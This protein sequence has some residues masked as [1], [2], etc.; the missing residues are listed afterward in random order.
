MNAIT[1]IQ[2]A[3]VLT[4]PLNIRRGAFGQITDGVP[5]SISALV[6]KVLTEIKF[7]EGVVSR[8][9]RGGFDAFNAD[10][11]GFD[12]E[13]NLVAIQLRHS[14]KRRESD[15]LN[16]HKWYALA[17]ID[18]GQLFSH[19]IPTSFRRNPDIMRASAESVVRWAESKIFGVPL[20]R[21]GTIIR[22][23]DVALVPVRS[24]PRSA[25][26]IDGK[27]YKYVFC[28]SH[29][30]TIDGTAYIDNS[31]ARHWADG[32]VQIDHLPGQHRS[33][34]GQGRFEIVVGE[35]LDVDFS[36]ID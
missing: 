34:D 27:D 18:E 19:V 7:Y 12:V 11:Y 29:K 13:R 26:P 6:E 1:E 16:T 32:L 3:P 35:R 17:G 33:I 10:I 23:G 22:Q 21:I 2:P 4:S 9:N 30:I 20:D 28:G 14:S 15:W 31:T 36:T 5:A 8:N 24:I 25:K